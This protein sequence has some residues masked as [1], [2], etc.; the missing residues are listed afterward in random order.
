MAPPPE[1]GTATA[2][3]TDIGMRPFALSLPMA[4][5]RAREAAMHG[6][7]PLLVQHGLTEQQWRVL[8]ALADATEPLEVGDLIDRTFLL[9]PSLSRILANLEQRNLIERAA[10]AHDQRRAAISL[11]SGGHRL[12]RRVA[13]LSEALYADI[14]AAIGD[15]RLSQLHELLEELAAIQITDVPEEAP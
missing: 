8:R 7:R 3:S 10:A 14:E 9:G 11:S 12:V 6:F 5:M 1:A 2:A 4:L 15:T 13:P